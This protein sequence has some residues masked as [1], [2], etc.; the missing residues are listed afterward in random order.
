MADLGSTTAG[1]ELLPEIYEQVFYS[2]QNP[3]LVIDLE[4]VI[5]DANQAAVEFLEFQDRETLLGTAV[6]DILADPSILEEVGEQILSRE[7]WRGEAEI[8]T[9]TDRIRIGVGTAAPIAVDGDPELIAGVFT[10]MTQQRRSTNSLKILNRILRHNIRNDAT[11]LL[12]SLHQIRPEADDE[13]IASAAAAARETLNDILGY[14]DTARELELLLLG[15]GE[16]TLRV[17]DLGGVVE[18]VVADLAGE[19]DHATLDYPEDVPHIPIIGLDSVTR[20]VREVVENAIVHTSS[21]SPTVELSVEEGDRTVQLRVADDGPGVPASD[22]DLIFG[23]EELGQ[24]HHG[25]GFSLFFVDQV[26]DVIGGDVWVED[27]DLGGAAFV[28]EF[29]RPS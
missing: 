20:V 21:A 12:G 17:H 27:S 24:L 14:A 11:R 1:D 13:Q 9:A 19:Y 25:D 10:D 18:S 22:R 4:F 3:A 8:R 16:S 5:R 2:I 26:M 7:Y 15:H 6:A 28:L 23:R 29:H